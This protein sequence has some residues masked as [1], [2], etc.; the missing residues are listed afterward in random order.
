MSIS[1]ISLALVPFS[2]VRP[3]APPAAAAI[4]PAPAAAPAPAPAPTPAPTPATPPLPTASHQQAC[5]DSPRKSPLFRA[6]MS[7]L[8]A[9]A[10]PTAA[11]ASSTPTGTAA[12]PA[13]APAAG[14]ALPATSND[15]ADVEQAVFQFARALMQAL[16]GDRGGEREDGERRGEGEDGDR[17][18]H[19]HGHHYGQYKNR[20]Q[21]PLARI[22]TLAARY[23]SP[24]AAAPTTASLATPATDAAAPAHG[25]APTVPGTDAQGAAVAPAAVPAAS[26]IVAPKQS[27]VAGWNDRLMSA[28]DQLQQALGRPAANAASLKES[29]SGFLRDLATQLR[30]DGSTPGADPSA[31]GSLISVAA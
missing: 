30:G 20:W 10:T 11:P 1:S 21:D 8:G 3:A 13:A 6:L 5:C 12:A 19:D 22:E 17:E 7:A 4:A 28:F 27:P 24:A 9:M 14:Q 2:G 26:G 25:Q 18:H 15:H 16:R 23:A 31:P 29:L